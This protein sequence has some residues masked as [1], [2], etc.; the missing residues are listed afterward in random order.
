MK[1]PRRLTERPDG[2]GPSDVRS[3]RAGDTEA[4]AET[5]VQEP[6]QGT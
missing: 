1:C 4:A 5:A 2:P 3:T 6:F